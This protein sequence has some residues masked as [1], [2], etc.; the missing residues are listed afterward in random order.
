M[1]NKKEIFERFS[2]ELEKIKSNLEITTSKIRTETLMVTFKEIAGGKWDFITN[3]IDFELTSLEIEINTLMV[4]FEK[5]NNCEITYNLTTYTSRKKI[6]A[7]FN[8]HTKHKI[9][10]HREFRINEFLEL[11]LGEITEDYR[12]EIYINHKKFT[13]CKYLLMNIPA[14]NIKDYDKINSIDEAMKLYNQIENEH[15]KQQIE[16][17]AE[18]WGH[19]SNL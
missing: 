1:I 15:L 11:R 7:V 5:K 9:F 2:Q 4:D 10:F 19:C 12:T 18:F 17:E 8:F 14:H 6:T 13:H 3:Y 16:P